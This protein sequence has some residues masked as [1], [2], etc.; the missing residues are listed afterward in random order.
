[1]AIQVRDEGPGCACRPDAPCNA[2]SKNA[3]AKDI[4]PVSKEAFLEMLQAIACASNV[5]LCGREMG[6]FSLKAMLGRT[7]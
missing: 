3:K 1:M 6:R 4:E 2:D 7:T 5:G